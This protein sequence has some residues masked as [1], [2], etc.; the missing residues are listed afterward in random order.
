MISSTPQ[1]SE[2]CQWLAENALSMYE[3]TFAAHKLNSLRKVSMLSDQ[4][5]DQINK[6]FCLSAHSVSAET[7]VVLQG[8]RVALGA[9]VDV[10][11]G[12]V[13]ALPL[14][15]QLEIYSDP[16]V[17]G[18][19]LIGAQNQ[20]EVV[21]AKRKWIWMIL[22]LVL[23]YGV[24]QCVHG[25]R[26]YRELGLQFT[27]SS[28]TAVSVQ[29]SNDTLSWTDVPCPGGETC[30]FDTSSLASDLDKVATNWFPHQQTARFVKILPQVFY[31]RQVTGG[32]DFRL[33][34]LGGLQNSGSALDFATVQNRE[35][36]GKY[37]LQAGCRMSNVS[38]RWAD[39][40]ERIGEVQCCLPG[41]RLH[42]CTRDGC[43]SGRDGTAKQSW[44]GA[45]Q[46]CESKGWRLCSRL[47]MDSR[48]SS[49][50]CGS[51]CS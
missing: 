48:A 2:V 43:L 26:F 30:V 37:W 29:L 23:A 12:T 6:D 34:I 49:G 10:L 9:A 42:V 36:D 18:M 22:S 33:G 13:K 46:L 47:E 31:P 27:P 25:F 32:A 7:D 11:K 4:Q 17:S 8:Q 40:H 41:P 19:N 51:V 5:L 39:P 3:S 35:H 38:G 28:V 14:R 20:L 44:E 16:K 24:Y 21:A 1:G 15:E 45:K 50:C